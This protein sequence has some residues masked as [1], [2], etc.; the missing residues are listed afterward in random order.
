[1]PAGKAW[2]VET[3]SPQGVGVGVGVGTLGEYHISF[4]LL[5][6]AFCPPQAQMMLLK[7]WVAK[8]VRP[9][10]KAE[11]VGLLQKEPSADTQTSL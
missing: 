5:M 2:E 8:F 7:T 1:V 11:L 3:V 9:D 4:K 6:G 10:V